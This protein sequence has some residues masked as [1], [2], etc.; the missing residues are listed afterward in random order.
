MVEEVLQVTLRLLGELD[1][2]EGTTPRPGGTQCRR[3]VDRGGARPS[4]AHCGS[5]MDGCTFAN[6]SCDQRVVDDARVP[7][8]GGRLRAEHD[9]L[10]LAEGGTDLVGMRE[11]TTET[12]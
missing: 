3:D 8:I 1:L 11:Q 4:A 5:H 6:S 12:T 2:G 9:Q 7:G 10:A